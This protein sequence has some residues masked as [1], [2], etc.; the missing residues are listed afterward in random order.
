MGELIKEFW[1]FLKVRKKYWL[2]PIIITLILLASCLFLP[3]M[4]GLFHHLYMPFDGCEPCVASAFTWYRI[5][6]L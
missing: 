2:A 4:Q 1:D 3:E 5:I 6:F